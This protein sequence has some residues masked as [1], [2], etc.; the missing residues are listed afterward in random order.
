MRK[1]KGQQLSLPPLLVRHCDVPTGPRK[2]RPDERLSDEA[3]DCFASLA[4]TA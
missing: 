1:E 4:M 3:M 2:A